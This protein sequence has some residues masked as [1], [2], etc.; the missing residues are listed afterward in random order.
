MQQRLAFITLSK[1]KP[2][3]WE[4]FFVSKSVFAQSAVMV[5]KLKNHVLQHDTNLNLILHVIV[6]KLLFL[7]ELYL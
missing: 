1:K 6:T 5:N 3:D 2:P 4:A 7:M